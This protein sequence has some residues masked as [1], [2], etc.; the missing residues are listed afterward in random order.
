M[1]YELGSGRIRADVCC[2]ACSI[3]LLPDTLT[4]IISTSRKDKVD[5]YCKQGRGVEKE[6]GNGSECLLSVVATQRLAMELLREES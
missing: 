1:A 4:V 6:K 5:W 3:P 2:A